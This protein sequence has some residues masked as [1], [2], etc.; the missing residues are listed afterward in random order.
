MKLNQ[1]LSVNQK[2]VAGLASFGLL[3]PWLR[4]TPAPPDV[5]STLR[6]FQIHVAG[7]PDVA[8]K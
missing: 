8:S 3:K 4:W 6:W 7:C 2:M 5:A 1:K